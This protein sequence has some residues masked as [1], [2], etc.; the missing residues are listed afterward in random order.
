MLIFIF[1]NC[2]GISILDEL[3]FLYKGWYPP[4]QL[5]KNIINASNKKI[6]FVGSANETLGGHSRNIETIEVKYNEFNRRIVFDPQDFVANDIDLS[7]N[8]IK[9]TEG[10]FKLG[11]KVIYTASSPAGGLVN[12]RMYYVIFYDETNIRLVEE[13]TELQSNNPN[14]VIIS[15]ATAGTLSKVN[16][17]LL[18]RKNQQL[19]FDVSDSSLSFIDDGVSYSAFKLQFFKDKEY[20]VIFFILQFPFFNGI[21][22]FLPALFKGYGYKTIFI[23]VDHRPRISGISKYG[24]LDRLFK[25]VIDIIRVFKIIKKPTLNYRDK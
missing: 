7:L 4:P 12:E 24:V 14:F 8:T 5:V 22:R 18:L 15:S 17:P 16:P 11:D 3:V 25:G 10:V 1:W 6:G 23:N 20:K 13:R 21:H 2:L 19:K 9:V